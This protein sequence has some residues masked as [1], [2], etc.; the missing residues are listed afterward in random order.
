VG[1]PL[2]EGFP[3]LLQIRLGDSQ[4]AGSLLQL[5]A[6]SLQSHKEDIELLPPDLETLATSLQLGLL[7]RE[8][9]LEVG[10]L[11]RE[12]NNLQGKSLLPLGQELLPARYCKLPVEH[13]QKVG[14]IGLL[15]GFEL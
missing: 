13:L 15:V 10:P 3:A 8:A 5:L 6:P 11:S 12:A 14:S 7:S 9:S 2:G 4:L 1:L